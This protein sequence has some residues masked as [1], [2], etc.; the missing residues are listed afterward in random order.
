MK[1][2]DFGKIMR[3][4]NK[5]MEYCCLEHLTIGTELSEDTDTMTVK[6]MAET[7]RYW[8]STY[9]EDGHLNHELKSE[10]P[11]LWRSQMGALWRFWYSYKDY[12][13][14]SNYNMWM[15]IH[16]DYKPKKTPKTKAKKTSKVKAKAK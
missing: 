15:L 9:H 2:Y 7:C 5:I 4:Y 8:W 6:E 13:D 12:E 14:Q 1:T 3:R 16:S 10:N 11:K